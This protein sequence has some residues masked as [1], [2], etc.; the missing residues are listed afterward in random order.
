MAL[1]MQKVSGLLAGCGV[2]GRFLGAQLRNL[3]RV[4]TIFKFKWLPWK[5]RAMRKLSS[6]QATGSSKVLVTQE[7]DG[8]ISVLSFLD[9]YKNE[10]LYTQIL[11]CDDNIRHGRSDFIEWIDAR[12]SP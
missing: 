11:S 2:F 6:W 8:K 12:D 5:K 3:S 4:A 10:T 7:A 1:A 9:A